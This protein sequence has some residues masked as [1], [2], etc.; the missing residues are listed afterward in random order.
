MHMSNLK[1]LLCKFYLI[2][3]FLIYY[4]PKKLL[5]K[6]VLPIKWAL[7]ALKILFVN[8]SSVSH[9]H[10]FF[11]CPLEVDCIDLA[12]RSANHS[13]PQI[14]WAT[15][16][17]KHD[18]LIRYSFVFWV[19]M[20]KQTLLWACFQCMDLISAYRAAVWSYTH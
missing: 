9:K 8:P 4:S 19:C 13:K 17:Y 1:M 11:F 10:L 5:P 2:C 6:I 14:R 15:Q 20:S 18:R 16:L 12:D 7:L 3:P